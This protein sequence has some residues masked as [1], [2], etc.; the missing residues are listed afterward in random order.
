METSRLPRL[1]RGAKPPRR[2]VVAL[3]A[4]LAALVL[5]AGA[6]QA[7]VAGTCAD[8]V[9]RLAIVG[10]SIGVGVGAGPGA[11]YGHGLAWIAA[12]ASRCPVDVRSFAHVRDTS[13]DVLAHGH[14]ESVLRF[15]PHLVVITVGGNDVNHAL[16]AGR[17]GPDVRSRLRANL[18][19]ILR[20]LSAPGRVVVLAGLYSPFPPGHPLAADADAWLEEVGADMAEV[21]A[22]SNAL[23]VPLR[24]AFA[25]KAGRLTWI[26]RGDPHPSPEGHALIARCIGHALGLTPVSCGALG[27]EPHNAL[28]RSLVVH[29]AGGGAPPNPVGSSEE[30]VS[31]AEILWVDLSQGPQLA[32]PGAVLDVAGDGVAAA[33]LVPVPL[34]AYA[35]LWL[36]VG[37]RF[38]REGPPRLEA[39]A[40]RFLLYSVDVSIHV[41]TDP[42]A[43]ELGARWTPAGPWQAY[44]GLCAPLGLEGIHPAAEEGEPPQPPCPREGRLGALFWLRWRF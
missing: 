15:D 21:A 20:R 32:G 43:L 23:W 9:L 3:L 30:P 44:A 34:N 7:G 26:T 1:L 36:Q 29:V 40:R 8:G 6:G 41:R 39:G 10:D 2:T 22:G 17:M 16:V 4:A 33:A 42:L 28:P 18:E 27:P 12:G 13:A 31:R 24:E 38:V 37:P 25:G 35:A 5:T 14:V 11:G 19:E